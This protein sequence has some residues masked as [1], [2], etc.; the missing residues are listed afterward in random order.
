MPRTLHNY[1][2]TAF[3]ERIFNL[4]LQTSHDLNNDMC[5]AKKACKYFKGSA[6]E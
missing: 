3:M 6:Y 2:I 5:Q 4:D 1:G